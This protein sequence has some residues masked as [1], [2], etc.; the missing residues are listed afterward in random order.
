MLGCGTPTFAPNGGTV[1]SGSTVTIL[2]APGFPSNGVIYYT[3]DGTTP[4][5]GSAIYAGPIQVTMPETLSA[6]AFAQGACSDSAVATAMFA[7]ATVGPVAT[8][9]FN[10]PAA[11]QTNDFVVALSSAPGAAICYTLD[12][13][14]PPACSGAG[15][16]GGACAAGSTAYNPSSAIAIQGS[17]TNPS[18]GLV[19]VTAVACATGAA[20]GAPV[21]QTYGLKAAAPAFQSPAASVITYPGASPTVS[22]ATTASGADVPSIYVTTD[23]TTPT[24]GTGTEVN[25]TAGGASGTVPVTQSASFRAV[26][27]KHGYAASD[28]TLAAYTVQLNPPAVAQGSGTYY[29]DVHPALSLG[30]AGQNPS[31][32]WVCYSTSGM[33]PACAVSANACAAGSFAESS[34]PSTI[35]TTGTVLNAVTCTPDASKY[36]QSPPAAPQTYTLQLGPI[37][38]SPNGGD[39]PASG[40][41]ATIVIGNSKG[42]IGTAPPAKDYAFLCWTNDDAAPEPDCSCAHP[43]AATSL[44]GVHKSTPTMRSEFDGARVSAPN[45]LR[46]RAVGCDGATPPNSRYLPSNSP[47]AVAQFNLPTQLRPPS[48][49]PAQGTYANDQDVVLSNP[50]AIAVVFCFTTN[51]ADP[52]TAAGACAPGGANA[53]GTTCLPAVTATGGSKPSETLGDLLN[54]TGLDVRALAC[55]PTLGIATSP[56]ASSAYTL[57][58]ARPSVTPNTGPITIGETLTFA[59]ATASP[60]GAPVRFYYTTDGS[61]PAC[62][63][64]AHV[65]GGPA[66]SGTTSTATYPVTGL[67]S[68]AP[69]GIRVIGCRDGYAASAVSPV[70]TFSSFGVDSPVFAYASGTYDDVLAPAIEATPSFSASYWLCTSQGSVH[71]HCSGTPG[72]CTAGSPIAGGA[73]LSS[74][75]CATSMNPT[76]ALHGLCGV[77]QPSPYIT[78]SGTVLEAVSCAK[79]GATL[80][81]SSTTTATYTLQVSDVGFAPAAGTQAGTLPSVTVDVLPS[82]T[83]PAGSPSPGSKGS[84][85]QATVCVASGS[86][87]PAMPPPH[88]PTVCAVTGNGWSCGPGPQR[89]ATDLSVTSTFFGFAC[90]TGM[91]ASVVRKAKYTFGAYVHANFP[92]TG[93]AADFSASQ[94]QLPTTTSGTAAY[95]TW[96]DASLYVGFDVGTHLTG[97]LIHFYVATTS[98]GTQTADTTTTPADGAEPP[99]HSQ[100]HVFVSIVGSAVAAVGVNAWDG[101][102]WRPEPAGTAVVQHTGTF[103]EIKVPLGSPLDLGAFLVAGEDFDPTQATKAFGAWPNNSAGSA[104][105]DLSTRGQSE[106][107]QSAK[108]PNDPTNTTH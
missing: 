81:E 56:V 89:A 72:G 51:G 2:A 90:K 108:A 40:T 74:A 100:F 32:A 26:A 84:T 44:T 42:D 95:V 33:A 97:G 62:G 34:I 91:L 82:T 14:T 86:T 71:P 52:T 69:G 77:P 73:Q 45:H 75:N 16:T 36:A 7:L 78:V 65:T 21:S 38:F 17:V 59:S 41:L 18:S 37:Q 39:V 106:N 93:K 79:P 57:Q 101:T 23:G 55:D 54:T 3:T 96:D 47:A 1:A 105:G 20:P 94:E 60:A 27:C 13:T 80:Y 24:C 61:A 15:G 63:T 58:V 30:V 10:P 28:I 104:A 70:T 5:H 31:T 43:T 22:T 88:S 85:S 76:V 6:M 87:A 68:L 11:T 46:L 4:T 49:A 35:T 92:F 12:A 64:G 50:N 83:P 9:S 102:M 66:G 103:Y 29:D 67:E 98:N 107:L 99:A 8:V 19:T 53:G 48:I 25:G